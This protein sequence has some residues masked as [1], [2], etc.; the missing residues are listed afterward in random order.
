MDIRVNA[1]CRNSKSLIPLRV[2]VL[3]DDFGFV[4]FVLVFEFQDLGMCNST[5]C[6]DVSVFLEACVSVCVCVRER[7]RARERVCVVCVVVHIVHMR[8]CMVGSGWYMYGIVC[9]LHSPQRGPR[10]VCQLGFGP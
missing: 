3:L 2:Q 4:F 10:S 9:C 8:R 7:E 5:H 6:V 1:D